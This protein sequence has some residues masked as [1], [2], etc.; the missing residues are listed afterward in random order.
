MLPTA[1]SRP[2]LRAPLRGGFASL[3]LGLAHVDSGTCEHDGGNEQELLGEAHRRGGGRV[4]GAGATPEYAREA[5]AAGAR[6]MKQPTAA[7]MRCL[8]AAQTQ[9]RRLDD[10]HGGTEHIILGVLTA[11]RHAADTPPR[12]G[13][14]HDSLRAPLV[15]E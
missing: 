11:D 6:A 15:D 13:I 5:V 1:A 7:S 3:D 10:D 2:P 9:S 12:T 4:P 14:P 8:E